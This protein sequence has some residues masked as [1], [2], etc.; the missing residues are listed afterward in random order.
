[1]FE[2]IKLPY[3]Y[4]ALEPHIDKLTVET[5]YE[6]HHKTYTEKFNDLMKKASGMDGKS[7]YEVLHSLDKLPEEIRT[8][9][10]NNGGGF[11]NHNLYFESLSPD[12][13]KPSGKLAEMLDNDFGG[14]EKML[15]KLN[16][17]ATTKLFG[18]GWSWLVLK[19]GKLDIA[20]SP[21][22]DLP[23]QKEK[24]V[25]LL[26]LD[27]WEHAYY[28]KYKNGKKS[29]VEAFNKIINWKVVG[30]RLEKAK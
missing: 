1:M 8:G 25:E 10:R 4:D 15:E 22:Q 23:S 17:A 18:S 9:V 26:P 16:D 7:A 3:S 14:A 29:Y 2:R 24:C 27:M 5:H 12:G 13:G 11:Y 21:N 30:E 6:K 19:D 20:I 28:L